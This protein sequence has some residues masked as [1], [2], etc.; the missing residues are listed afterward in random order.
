MTLFHIP[1]LARHDSDST[2]AFFEGMQCPSLG[3]VLGFVSQAV[4]TR[5]CLVKAAQA[6]LAMLFDDP[7]LSGAP[8]SVPPLL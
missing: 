1:P 7:L 6:H 5:P 3:Y 4:T 2:A 8:A